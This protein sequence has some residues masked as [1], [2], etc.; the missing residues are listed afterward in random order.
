M[1]KKISCQV[2][3]FQTEWNVVD[4]TGSLYKKMV[5]KKKSSKIISIK[6]SSITKINEMYNI[7]NILDIEKYKLF[8]TVYIHCN[9]S[10]WIHRCDIW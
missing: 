3:Q 9:C 2:D 10:A 6:F 1:Y 7:P 4:F 5:L 8:W